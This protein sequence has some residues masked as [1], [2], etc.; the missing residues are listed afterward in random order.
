MCNT[1]SDRSNTTWIWRGWELNIFWYSGYGVQYSTFGQSVDPWHRNIERK[2]WNFR[3]KLRRT[4]PILH[5]NW[6]DES[7]KNVDTTKKLNNT[8]P[9]GKRIKT[10]CGRIGESETQYSV[11]FLMSVISESIEQVGK[12]NVDVILWRNKMGGRFS[13]VYDR[14]TSIKKKVVVLTK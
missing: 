5:Q 12:K 2:K 3:T 7:G 1:T 6:E 9:N 13:R 4:C 8:T 11:F 14:K 10:N